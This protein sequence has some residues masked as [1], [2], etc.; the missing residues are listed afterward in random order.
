MFG[1]NIFAFRVEVTA[2]MVATEV[3]NKVNRQLISS[4][5]VAH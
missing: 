1:A 2:L 3:V 5:D 4:D